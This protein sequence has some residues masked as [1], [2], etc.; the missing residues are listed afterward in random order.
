MSTSDYTVQTRAKAQ[1]L[2]VWRINI[3]VG[4]LGLEKLAGQTTRIT[5][6]ILEMY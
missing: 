3:T 2:R 6:M 5:R 1:S 4:Q